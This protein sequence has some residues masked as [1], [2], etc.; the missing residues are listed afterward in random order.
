[1][2]FSYDNIE[3]QIG[4]YVFVVLAITTSHSSSNY[5]IHETSQ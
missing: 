5:D 4:K 1:M 2:S 3:I